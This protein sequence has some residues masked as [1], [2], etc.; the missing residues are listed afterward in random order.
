[1]ATLIGHLRCDNIRMREAL[2]EAQRVAEDATVA[3]EAEK[4]EKAELLAQLSRLQHA[5]DVRAHES[6]AG[7]SAAPG[8]EATVPG[9]DARREESFALEQ[10]LIKWK[11]KCAEA[12]D[13]ADGLELRLQALQPGSAPGGL[14]EATAG[15]PPQSPPAPEGTRWCADA[16]EKSG[17]K[18]RR[19]LAKMVGR[20]FRPRPVADGPAES[21]ATAPSAAEDLAR[22]REVISHLMAELERANRRADRSRAGAGAAKPCGAATGASLA[23]AAIHVA[24]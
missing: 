18:R 5:P 1:M 12:V 13:R 15:S 7:E 10:E 20:M 24:P 21:P 19:G 16:P 9:G 8:G 17:A 2:V 11:L 22:Q 6:P 23:A 3:L 14:E 4:E